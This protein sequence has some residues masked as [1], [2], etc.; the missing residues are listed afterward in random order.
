[1]NL[2]LSPPRK[3]FRV[4]E[5]TQLWMKSQLNEMGPFA[6]LLWISHYAGLFVQL[7]ASGDVEVDNHVSGNGK[8]C[9]LF[10]F[11]TRVASVRRG[12]A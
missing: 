3:V 6:A 2:T 1:M 8:P 7:N 5:Q 12:G 10:S 4:R 9:V 11:N